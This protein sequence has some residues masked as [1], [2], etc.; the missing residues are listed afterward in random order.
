MSTS[1]PVTHRG[2]R[3]ANGVGAAGAG[4]GSAVGG[5]GV[6][7]G[8]GASLAGEHANVAAK[9]AAAKAA[10]RDR[11]KEAFPPPGRVDITRSCD[12]AGIVAQIAASWRRT[13]VT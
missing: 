7:S 1:P 4:A 13:P 3:S 5:C 8:G 12:P 6:A 9:R 2:R 10:D 11:C